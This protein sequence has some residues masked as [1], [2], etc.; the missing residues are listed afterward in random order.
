ML[1]RLFAKLNGAADS[2]ERSKTSTTS[3]PQGVTK[4]TPSKRGRKS[5]LV[6]DYFASNDAGGPKVVDKAE[7]KEEV[8]ATG[9][10]LLNEG[11]D[12]DGES[13]HSADRHSSNL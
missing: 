9:F 4:E 6:T 11:Y 10:N 2:P 3:K 13:Q 7:E 8:M 12:G 5:K 1:N